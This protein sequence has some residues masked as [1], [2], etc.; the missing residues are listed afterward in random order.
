MSDL[1]NNFFVY[2]L[3]LFSRQ[4]LSVI[5]GWPGTLSVDQ[6]SFKLRSTSFHLLNTGLIP[7]IRS[8]L[9]HLATN[10]STM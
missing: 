8:S 2:Y 9:N 7:D 6:A 3:F 4:S 10:Q 1:A 5:P